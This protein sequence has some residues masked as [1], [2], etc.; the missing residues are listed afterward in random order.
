ML[1]EEPNTEKIKQH[2]GVN[3]AQ[4]KTMRE[5]RRKGERSG[6]DEKMDRSI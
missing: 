4:N 3:S 2:E 1:K 6:A 5:W